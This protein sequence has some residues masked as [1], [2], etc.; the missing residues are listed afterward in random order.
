MNSAL[1]YTQS[2]TFLHRLNPLL[3]LIGLVVVTTGIVIYPNLILTV[4]LLV[5][6]LLGF[7]LAGASMKLS[8]RRT[9]FLLVF[10][11]LLLVVQCIITVNGTVLFYVVPAIG[12]TPPQFPITAF[13][14]ERGLAIAARFLLIV[15]SSMLFVSVT[16]PTLLAHSLSKLRIS[17]RYTFA[18]IIALR[19]LPLFDLESTTVRNA[20]RSRGITTEV[21]SPRK[22]LRTVRYT[23]FPLLI[24]ALSRVDTLAMSMDGR[25][26]GY[27]PTRTYTRTSR[28]MKTDSVVALFLVGYMVFCVLS[29]LG[30]V[31]I[32]P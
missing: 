10:S 29:A 5:P 26:F 18:L 2:A 14:V 6:V 1:G 19:F 3:K 12:S 24:S 11:V 31:Q 27:A 28:W 13:G 23:F 7:P 30:I 20:Q 17:Y 21:G 16:D 4:L 32:L 25:G 8:R 9:K 22:L 15:F